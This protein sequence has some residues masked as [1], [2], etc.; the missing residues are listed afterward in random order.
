MAITV[1]GTTITFNDGTTQST[2]ATAGGAP[3]FLA[4]GAVMLLYNFARTSYAPNQNV[5]AANTGYGTDG[6]PGNSNPF[7]TSA[8][9]YG[10]V[11]VP[12]SSAYGVLTTAA[13][14]GTWRC[15]SGVRTSTY[16]S[17]SDT[18][19]AFPFLAIRTA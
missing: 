5:T 13:V 11:T 3:A 10:N 15:L 8:L 6:L 12:G 7:G 16:D 4:V 18:T 19:S 2:A 17:C 9:R 1:G 14:T